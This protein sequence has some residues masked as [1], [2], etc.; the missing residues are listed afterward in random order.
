MSFAS[1]NGGI[2]IKSPLAGGDEYQIP[3]QTA[4]N[5]TGFLLRKS[6][7]FTDVL[8]GS[9]QSFNT[10]IPL[11]ATIFFTSLPIITNDL[12]IK[13]TNF[14]VSISDSI[15]EF[16]TTYALIVSNF[17]GGEDVGGYVNIWYS[18]S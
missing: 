6:V 18:L 8:P 11:T 7:V 12:D 3:F 13:G 15:Y 9:S 2:P 4:P 5:K 1:C 17:E 16:P 14:N 10:T